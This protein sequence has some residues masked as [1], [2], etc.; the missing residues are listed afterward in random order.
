MAKGL[1]EKVTA[2]CISRKSFFFIALTGNSDLGSEWQKG[3]KGPHQATRL[4]N[5][6]SA[7]SPSPTPGAR[8]HACRGHTWH[9]Q[10]LAHLGDFCAVCDCCSETTLFQPSTPFYCLL[11]SRA[12]PRTGVWPEG[13]GCADR[14]IDVVKL[15]PFLVKPVR[16]ANSFSI[17]P[18][19][20]IPLTI[21]GQGDWASKECYL[22]EHDC[23]PARPVESRSLPSIVTI[24]AYRA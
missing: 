18:N 10:A 23:H 6:W 8:Q 9:A 22:L 19:D 1:G 12:S 16:S 24:M 11:A 13:I 3:G 14:W 17:E 5:S 2:S 4:T 7:W 20:G 15:C 21:I